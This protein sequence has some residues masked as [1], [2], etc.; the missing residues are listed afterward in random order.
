MVIDT[1]GVSLIQIDVTL[2]NTGYTGTCTAICKLLNKRMSCD[3]T[4][5]ANDYRISAG[6][7]KTFEIHADHYWFTLEQVQAYPSVLEYFSKFLLWD[8]MNGGATLTLAGA[9][10][11][12]QVLLSTIIQTDQLVFITNF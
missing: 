4:Q 8:D 5:T 9:Y 3:F 7:S 12:S 11:S 6:Q 10:H 2:T 1:N